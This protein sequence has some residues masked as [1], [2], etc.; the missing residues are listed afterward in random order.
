MHYIADKHYTRALFAGRTSVAYE[1]Y[2]QMHGKHSIQLNAMTP[3]LYLRTIKDKNIE[4]YNEFISQ[5]THIHQGSQNFGKRSFTNLAYNTFGI[6]RDSKFHWN[7]LTK[8]NPDYNIVIKRFHLYYNMK[9]VT[10]GI[11]RNLII[12]FPVFVQPY[13]QQS[14]TLHQLETVPVPI[15]DKNTKADSYIQLQ[16]KKPYLALNMETYINVR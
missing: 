15:V 10:F 3:M 14:L 7:M 13:T 8:T 4:I 5:P 11:E 9:L 2:S 6:E 12:Q 1:Y 16:I